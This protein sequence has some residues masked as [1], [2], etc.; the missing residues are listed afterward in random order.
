MLKETNRDLLKVYAGKKVFY[1][2]EDIMDVY[3]RIKDGKD[4]SI[5]KI[6]RPATIG[7]N[8]KIRA[9]MEGAAF[10]EYSTGGGFRTSQCIYE[11]YIYTVENQYPT[12]L[13][14]YY[15]YED[16]DDKFTEENMVYSCD[17]NEMDKITPICRN[18]YEYLIMR[19]SE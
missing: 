12:V 14:V 8:V 9:M 3:A 10:E 11:D 7:D 18:L 1:T 16:V 15:N 6:S 13:T 17:I 5:K 2:D 19:M 4:W